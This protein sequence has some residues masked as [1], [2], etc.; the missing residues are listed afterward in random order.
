MKILVIAEN[1]KTT[2]IIKKHLMPLGF[3]FIFYSNPVKAMDNIPEIAPEMVIFSAED[4]PMH[5]EPFLVVLRTFFSHKESIFILLK[6][7]LFAKEE[8]EKAIF[9]KVNGLVSEDVTES[10]FIDSMKAVFT[11]HLIPKESR[12]NRRFFV[13]D[14][15]KISFIFNHPETMELVTGKVVEISMKGV[16]ISLSEGAA[17]FLTRGTTIKYCSIKIED[18][19]ITTDCTVFR[20]ESYA[21]L[22]FTDMDDDD[23]DFIKSYFEKKALEHSV[24]SINK[25]NKPKKNTKTNKS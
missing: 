9:L 21:T 1:E 7:A 8:A 20:N 22:L 18:K 6:T 15:D 4:Y 11:R 23:S 10:V 19:I 17:S 5:W 12:R 3:N 2:S 14:S 25:T 24:F 16:T 13:I